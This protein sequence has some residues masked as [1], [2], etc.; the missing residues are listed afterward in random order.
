MPLQRFSILKGIYRPD[1]KI[2][3][4]LSALI[5]SGVAM[6]L[7]RGAQDNYL[8]E[9]VRIDAFERGIVE[10]F[11]E[12]PGFMVV[13]FL[14]WMYR[15]TEN[16]IFKTGLGLMAAGVTGFMLAQP[17]KIAVTAL[18]VIYSSGEHI[19]MPVR[20]SI[21][22]D[23]AKKDKG[24]A[25]LGIT[26][27][28]GHGGHIAGYALVS[29]AFALFAKTGLEKIVQFKTVFAVS[30]AL[31]IAAFMVSFALK[32]S[33][34]KVSRRRFYFD[35]KFF[36]YYMLEIFYG[37]R[38]QIFI[39]FAP[40]VLILNYGANAQVISLLL[41]VSALF[42]FIAS[43]LIGK[44]IDKAGYK[45]VMVG[46]TIILIVVCFLYGFSHRLFPAQIAFYVVCV[47]YVLDAIISVA[48]MASNVYVQDIASSQEEITA[49]VSTGISVN[50][51]ISILIALTGGLMWKLAGIELLFSFSAFLGLI[52]TLYAATIKTRKHLPAKDMPTE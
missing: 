35:K 2:G 34:Q 17:G 39:T 31:A 19:V 48:S 21:S 52:N 26:G 18:L 28:L 13:F 36:K 47:N 46:D 20:T 30:A 40:Y 37:A 42:A 44:L 22:L 1:V 14:A 4:F 23:I 38:K 49:T 24:G 29:V 7:Q 43:P 8:A 11:R 15:F 16:K 45:I 6:G 50:H 33:G 10:F 3:R 32:E 25:S 9:I 12:L 41:A 5:L 51:V 27:A